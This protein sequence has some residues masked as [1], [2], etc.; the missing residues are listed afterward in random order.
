[1]NLSYES[2]TAKAMSEVKSW[3]GRVSELN[4]SDPCFFE[5]RRRYEGYA[6]SVYLFWLDLCAGYVLVR[7]FQEFRALLGLSACSDLGISIYC[8]KGVA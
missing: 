6:F 2:L 7:D 1:M 3:L 5:D 4:P 8:R